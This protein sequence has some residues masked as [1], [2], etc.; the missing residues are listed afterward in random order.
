MNYEALVRLVENKSV[1]KILLDTKNVSK[2]TVHQKWLVHDFIKLYSK[3]LDIVV[4]SSSMTKGTVID[5]SQW[6]SLVVQ[7]GLKTDTARDMI[8]GL[9]QYYRRLIEYVE[10]NGGWQYVQY[11][12][13]SRGMAAA[14][15]SMH[16]VDL[17]SYIERVDQLSEDQQA[18]MQ[19]LDESRLTI[20]A[21][22]GAGKTT[23]LVHIVR[24]LVEEN[25]RVLVLMYNV[26]VKDQFVRRLK[27]LGVT[28]VLKHTE[29]KHFKGKNS[30]Q[31]VV[32]TIHKYV[33]E[34]LPYPVKQSSGGKVTFSSTNGKYMQPYEWDYCIVDEVQDLDRNLYDGAVNLVNSKHFIYAGD[35]RQNIAG[36]S[37]VFQR[38]LSSSTY[39]HK[40]RDNHRSYPD[41]VKVLNAYSE[42]NYSTD[43]HIEQTA[44]I[45]PDEYRSLIV[46]QIVKDTDDIAQRLVEHLLQY[47][48]GETFIIA[49]ISV[50]KYNYADVQKR[51]Y[52]LLLNT[53]RDRYRHLHTYN[54]AE[55]KS[56]DMQLRSDKDYF[57]TAKS[58]KGL[59]RKQ[60]IVYNVSD[61]DMY[62]SSEVYKRI[63]EE[64]VISHI[65]VA[66]SRPTHRLVILLDD[67]YREQYL[68]SLSSKSK[69]QHPLSNVFKSIGYS[70]KPAISS[71]ATVPK[72]VHRSSMSQLVT[73]TQIINWFPDQ[74]HSSLYTVEEIGSFKPVS[75]LKEHT[76]QLPD[77][78]GIYVEACIADHYSCIKS[79][80][81]CVSESEYSEGLTDVDDAYVYMIRGEYTM[82]KAMYS[83]KLQSHKEYA[84][85]MSQET[86][87]KYAYIAMRM[88]L[89]LGKYEEEV[90]NAIGELFKD[91]EPDLSAVYSYID[92]NGQTDCIVHQSRTEYKIYADRSDSDTRYSTNIVGQTDFE[93][94]EYVYEIKHSSGDESD[95]YVQALLYRMM[96]GLDTVVIN[97]KKGKIYRVSPRTD[98]VYSLLKR[99]IRAAA[100][101]E[102]AKRFAQGY[103]S[104][105]KL[106]SPSIKYVLSVDDEYRHT[107]DRTVYYER[108]IVVYDTVEKTVVDALSLVHSKARENTTVSIVAAR[109][110]CHRFYNDPLDEDSTMTTKYCQ[111][112]SKYSPENSV[113]MHWAGS[114]GKNYDFRRVQ[115]DHILKGLKWNCIDMRKIYE[116]YL[117][118]TRS[119]SSAEEKHSSLDSAVL[120]LFGESM[121][122]L[123]HRAYD[124][125]IAT[126]LVYIALTT[127]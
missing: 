24:R 22:P 77:L 1:V 6:C 35:Y 120:D 53:D 96:T 15:T 4:E 76:H 18:V 89:L 83:K 75:V 63:D 85:K 87:K 70:P 91:L 3:Q 104:Y 74:Y 49:P 64:S 103:C 114:E 121:H 123:Y 78:I 65:Y 38:I 102:T 110:D 80:H 118:N 93:H 107:K 90:D 51:V 113:I 125:C 32:C 40:I 127:K 84:Y 44:M 57:I 111:F 59:E 12:L 61:I 41:I 29:Q 71:T 116:Q 27:E 10:D 100:H 105:S 14:L 56:D 58:A 67:R 55:Y 42:S 69:K 92:G 52:N 39:V 82:N 98:D 26:A 108:S 46:E 66:L 37:D 16:S 33:Y 50:N 122:L 20:L 109:E 2:W 31:L 72:R 94:G 115:S 8:R 7:H 97:T 68:P 112:L 5:K 106:F 126:L 88:Y 62:C 28:N 25:K 73:V 124:D 117:Y 34:C 47:K 95:H 13:K 11:Y 19:H 30:R 99:V 79:R 54:P 101:T 45:E 23:T 9:L 36:D 21:G 86:D 43:V 81:I 17:D 119:I 60:V 48:P